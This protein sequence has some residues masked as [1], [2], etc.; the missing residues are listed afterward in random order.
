MLR[1]IIAENVLEY[2]GYLGES[3]TLPCIG[4]VSN[5][6][7]IPTHLEWRKCSKTCGALWPTIALAMVFGSSVTLERYNNTLAGYRFKIEPS[8]GNLLISE[9]NKNDEG[10]YM[11][12]WQHN[13]TVPLH[14]MLGM[15]LLSNNTHD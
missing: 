3:V 10:Y 11:C 12:V 2:K 14:L 13:R 7:S 8:S 6:T 1:Y 15:Y 5:E 4:F 9:F